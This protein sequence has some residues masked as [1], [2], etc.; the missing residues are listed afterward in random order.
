MESTTR[1]QSQAIA[2]IP[3]P[4]PCRHCGSDLAIPG[5]GKGPHHAK[6]SCA[7]CG[8]FSRWLSP[9]QAQGLG[10]TV[11]GEAA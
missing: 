2:P 8:R 4:W 10:L 3:T 7:D 1:Q 11:N 6:I 5:A 9:S